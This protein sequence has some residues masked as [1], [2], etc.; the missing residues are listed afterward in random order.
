VEVWILDVDKGQVT[1]I[2]EANINAN[3]G[4][5]ISWFKDNKSLLVKTLAESRKPLINTK[6]AVPNGPTVSVSDGSKAQNRTY[7]DL[8]KTPNDEFNFE[9]L[10]LSELK[11]VSMDGHTESFLPAAMYRNISFSPDG[12]YVMV[13]KIKRPFFLFSY[14]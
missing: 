5:T 4:S 8:L 2:T 3:M 7:Q 1:K 12:E 14:F 13:T 11:K 10:A 6:V 9:Q